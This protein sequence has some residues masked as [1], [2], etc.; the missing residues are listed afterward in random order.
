MVVTKLGRT[1]T[2]RATS[3]GDLVVRRL[4]GPWEFEEPCGA[5]RVLTCP[6]MR[7]EWGQQSFISFI[8]AKERRQRVPLAPQHGEEN[9]LNVTTGS[10]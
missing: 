6:G 5:R 8:T 10:L 1:Q 3:S 9:I 2:P 7:L 4:S